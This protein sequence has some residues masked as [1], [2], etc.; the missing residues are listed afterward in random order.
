MPSDL[1]GRAPIG[2][3]ISGLEFCRKS[4]NAIRPG[5]VRT[6]VCMYTVCMYEYGRGN[7]NVFWPSSIAETAR[8]VAEAFF[9]YPVTELK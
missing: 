6:Y 2:K 5:R 8:Q 1:C 4:K 7:W 9:I 3:A